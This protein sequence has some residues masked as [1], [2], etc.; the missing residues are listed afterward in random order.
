MAQKWRNETNEMS[1]SNLSSITKSNFK[2]WNTLR[3]TDLKAEKEF[4]FLLGHNQ[5][6]PK[7]FSMNTYC[8][9]LN[10]G[11]K[12]NSI[13]GQSRAEQSKDFTIQREEAPCELEWSEDKRKWIT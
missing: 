1:D 7:L 9:A 3:L 6:R 11:R 2:R 4:N 13:P 12:T 8:L 10:R 5:E